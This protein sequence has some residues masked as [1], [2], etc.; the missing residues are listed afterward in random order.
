MPERYKLV[1]FDV[2]GTLI[3][4]MQFVWVKL[5]KDL[6]MDP[7]K[8]NQA[9][10]EFLKG[11]ITF[12]EWADYDTNLWVR[13]G[14]T[15]QKIEESIVK[16][17]LM[18]GA[19]QTIKEL[20]RHGYKLAIISGG[21]DIVVDHFLGDVK[22][23]FSYIVINRLKFDENDNLKGID[24]PPEY[25][26]WGE[27]K[28]LVLK[29]IAEKEGISVDECVFIGD[30]NNDMDVIKEAGLGIAFNATPELSEAAD[31]SVKERDLKNVLDILGHDR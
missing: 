27:N 9:R 2:D 28:N 31:V 16:F 10:E 24:I 7:A 1:A 25:D 18:E 4:E 30:S 8:V 23:Y 5:H 29:S 17:R 19:K 20:H 26:G 21:L 12:R 11:K 15:R 14:V 3:D 13:N 6:G 22:K